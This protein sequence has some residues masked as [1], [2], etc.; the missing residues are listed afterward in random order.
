MILAWDP[1]A[2]VVDPRR[3]GNPRMPPS[4]MPEI[5]IVMVAHNEAD[6][7]ESVMRSFYKTVSG[8][9]RVAR[10]VVAEDGSTDGTKEILTALARELPLH[11]VLGQHRK[12]YAGAVRDAL[13]ATEAGIVLFVDSDGQYLASDFAGLLA[14]FK[15]ADMVIGSKIRRRDAYHRILMSRVFHAVTR[16]LFGIRLQDPDCGY[17]LIRGDLARTFARQCYLLPYSY[18]TEF[19]VRM[20][21]ASF[22]IHEV[23]VN[24]QPRLS[25][26]SKVYPLRK[27]PLVVVPQTVGLLKLWAELGRQNLS[28]RE[29]L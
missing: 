6:S 9:A 19:T 28:R 1:S 3:R 24:H 18:W 2:D 4:D 5:D 14:A 20:A 23:R 15:A 13:C 8:Y 17:R 26:N 12:G 21:K 16:I 22:K 10:I 7:I 11:L 27:I 29:A 25:G